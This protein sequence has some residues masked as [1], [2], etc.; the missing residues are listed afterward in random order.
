M[1]LLV[2]HSYTTTVLSLCY[3]LLSDHAGSTDAGRAANITANRIAL[4]HKGRAL[5]SA[6]LS[7]AVGLGFAAGRKVR[8][9]SVN[10]K[11]RVNARLASLLA[12][13]C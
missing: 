10:V 12:L 13:R 4:S 6:T 9:Y 2:E 1:P 5:L 8:Y 11:G 7:D 3:V